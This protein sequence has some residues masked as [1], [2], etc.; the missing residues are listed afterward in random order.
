MFAN[1]AILREKRRVFD[2]I[3]KDLD[4]LRERRLAFRRRSTMRNGK[5]V[6]SSVP[7]YIPPQ[8]PV[9]FQDRE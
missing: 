8:H 5:P 9:H 2:F 4:S 6:L 1:D 7:E 3:F